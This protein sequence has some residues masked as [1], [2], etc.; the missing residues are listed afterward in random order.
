MLIVDRD[1]EHDD[2]A[3]L[4]GRSL[5]RE[6]VWEPHLRPG[7]KLCVVDELGDT[8]FEIRLVRPPN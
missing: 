5:A 7:S 1:F 8:V 3:V 6:R 4:Y 2:A